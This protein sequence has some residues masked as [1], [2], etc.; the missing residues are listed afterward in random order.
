M[1][2]EVV[3][4]LCESQLS[5]CLSII[6]KQVLHRW[7]AAVCCDLEHL[8]KAEFLGQSLCC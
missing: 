5:T 8:L 2:G 7:S 3:G 4:F 1:R 6:T